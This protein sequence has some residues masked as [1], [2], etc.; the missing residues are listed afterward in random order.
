MFKR[1]M[2]AAAALTLTAGAAR[3]QEAPPVLSVDDSLICAGL[4]YAQSTLPENAGYA[5][6]VQAYQEMVRV[7]LRRAE[8][9]AAR[10]GK[11]TDGHVE[12]AAEVADTLLGQ[13][14]AAA[15][16]SG[17]YAVIADWQPIEDL[18]IAGGREPA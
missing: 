3:A 1:L 11:G 6:G 8:I 9:L 14:N 4:A 16:A 10:E 15:D 17:R 18:C 13:V 2:T 12:R 5:E 7:F